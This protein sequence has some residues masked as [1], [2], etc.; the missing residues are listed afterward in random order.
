MKVFLYEFT[1][2]PANRGRPEFQS[3][4]AEGAAMLA[5]LRTDFG[6]I[7]GLEVLTLGPEAPK[8]GF[9]GPS[10]ADEDKAFRDPARA[11]DFSLVVAP[12]CQGILLTRCCWV[13][14]VHGRLLGPSPA[15]VRLTADKLALAGH[16]RACG[17]ATPEVFPL[18]PG[19]TTPV[20]FP[21]VLKPR[22]GAGSQATFLVR[23]QADLT[24]CFE[25]ARIE[26]WEGEWV[27]QPFVPGRPASVAFLTGPGETVPLLP[28]AQRLSADGRF[29]Y[30][31]GSVPLPQ[32]LAR[33]AVSLA[34]RAVDAVAG[35][36]GYVGV[37][38]V[39]GAPEDGSGDWLIELN[40]RVTT[41]YVGLRALAKN[42]LAEAMLRVATGQPVEPQGW[43]PGTAVFQPDGTVQRRPE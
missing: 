5:A 15:A 18:R 30:L 37:D 19:A 3:L 21:A 22:D 14:E 41:S 7:P 2:A 10:P 32:P 17:L 38:L 35:L 6:R 40:P 33:R 28:A 20:R 23:R 1:R 36:Q 25:Q 42:N 43:R 9:P 34:R 16:W 12:E 11:A 13:E 27:V 39:L 8:P 29:H 26:G 24:A 31:G 4:Q